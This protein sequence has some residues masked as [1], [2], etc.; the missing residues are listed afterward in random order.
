M[1]KIYGRPNIEEIRKV[2]LQIVRE[3]EE[4]N[5]CQLMKKSS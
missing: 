5:K 1:T 4:Q 3:L 2:A